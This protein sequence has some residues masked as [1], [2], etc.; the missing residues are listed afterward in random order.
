MLTQASLASSYPPLHMSFKA[1][2]NDISLA[3]TAA[4]SVGFPV[5]TPAWD[6]SGG[7]NASFFYDNPATELQSASF[8]A[9]N[10]SADVYTLAANS[11]DPYTLSDHPYLSTLQ[12]NIARTPSINGKE[13]FVHLSKSPLT[14]ANGYLDINAF[15]SVLL[16]PQIAGNQDDLFITYLHPG[17]YYVTVVADAN[18]DGFI[19]QGDITHITQP[20]SITPEQNATIT[21]DNITVQ[22]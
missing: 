2:Q 9:Q 20:I 21:I 3:Q 16:F 13:L 4:T 18:D 14:D 10:G 5:N 15:N 11:G 22:N 17:D 12:L 6:F 7:F 8:L 1:K 19:S